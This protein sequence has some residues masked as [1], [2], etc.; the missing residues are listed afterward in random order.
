MGDVGHEVAQE[1]TRQVVLLMLVNH[2]GNVKSD[3]YL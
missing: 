1:A 2:L 3:M